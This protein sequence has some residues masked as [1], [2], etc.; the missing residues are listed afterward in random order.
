MPL[1]IRNNHVIITC[2]TSLKMDRKLYVLVCLLAGLVS[3][4]QL[5]F[6]LLFLNATV[7]HRIK[8]Q[9]SVSIS[10]SRQQIRGKVF[11]K[12]Q[13][14]FWVR[15]GRTQDWWDNFIRE[16][17]VPEEWKENFRMSRGSFMKLCDELCP[18][19]Q[20]RTTN[21]RSPVEVERQV[22]LT[23]YYLSD[24]G[25]LRKT[26]NAFGL[27]RSIVSVTVRKLAGV[28]CAHLGPK[29]IQLPLTDEEVI[30]KVTNFYHAFSVP[31]CIGAI[32]CT[33]INIKSPTCNPTDYIN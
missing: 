18:H 17:V 4:Y 1:L 6:L 33:H 9:V 10:L 29:Y 5:Y 32:D 27:S 31:Q 15:P 23:L 13:R 16:V 21:M 26:A 12:R 30:D 19:I 3:V 25:R 14:R 24:E 28:I 22:A 20:K 8:A 2:S 11:K 7:Y